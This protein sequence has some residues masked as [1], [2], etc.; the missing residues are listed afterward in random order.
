MG[1]MF[2]VEHKSS[3]NGDRIKISRRPVTVLVML[4]LVLSDWDGSSSRK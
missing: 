2:V 3:L 1:D 4:V